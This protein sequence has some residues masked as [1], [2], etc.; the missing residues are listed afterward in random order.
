ML[1]EDGRME[2]YTNGRISGSTQGAPLINGNP[3]IAMKV[4]YD[5]THQLLP[6]PLA[7]FSGA[8]DEVRLYYRALSPDQIAR[9]AA[10]APSDTPEEAAGLVLHLRSCGSR[11]QSVAVCPW[12]LGGK[13]LYPRPTRAHRK[14]KQQQKRGFWFD[15]CGGG[16]GRLLVVVAELASRE[17]ELS[18]VLLGLRPVWW[19]GS[20]MLHGTYACERSGVWWSVPVLRG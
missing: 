10:R 3:A 4:G 15:K 19:V 13:L 12:R 9:L 2:V 16:P 20:W 11:R 6:D 8:L 14:R 18:H 17:L 1:R 5:D 7:P